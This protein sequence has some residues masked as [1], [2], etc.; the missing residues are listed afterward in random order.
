MEGV[1]NLMSIISFTSIRHFLQAKNNI[2]MFNSIYFKI[3]T[4]PLLLELNLRNAT[5][6]RGE[7]SM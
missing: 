2:T 7:V 5:I 6:L 1:A 3:K 4:I